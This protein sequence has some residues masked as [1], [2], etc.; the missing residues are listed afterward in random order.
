MTGVQTCALPIYG[1]MVYARLNPG[2]ENSGKLVS[3]VR[4]KAG[5]LSENE[6]IETVIIDGPPGEGCP[7]IASITNVDAVIIDRKSV[8]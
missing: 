5:Q 1:K 7:V 2:A 6:N 8:V 4:N 3:I